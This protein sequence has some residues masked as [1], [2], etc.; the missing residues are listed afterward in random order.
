MKENRDT[1]QEKRSP[2]VSPP[3]DVPEYP[4]AKDTAC[5]RNLETLSVKNFR[6]L[7]QYDGTH[8]HGWQR[9]PNGLTIQESIENCLR[10]IT[11]ENTAISGAGRTDAG[12]HALGQTV[13]FS[14]KTRHTPEIFMRALN[15][16][17]PP[18]IRALSA[19]KAGDSFHARFS[20]KTKV[21]CYVIAN[22]SHVSPFCSRYAWHVPQ[23]L[24]PEPMR[25]SLGCLIG[26]NDFS[27]FR[28]SGCMSLSPVRTILGTD[29][30]VCERLPF[31]PFELGGP[32]FVIR[33]EADSFLR[34]MVR[35]IVGTVYEIGSGRRPH[36]DMEAVLVAR[37]RMRA[38]MTAPPVGLFLE[39]VTY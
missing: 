37:K 28:A 13:S 1:V 14:A 20:A 33:I 11:G 26:E 31:L 9:Q 21:Y 23:P 12:V 7:F 3:H 16:M 29:L 8:Y 6:L 36:D 39:K 30:I 38:G 5:S 19:E 24:D 25:E 18:D 32:F 35:N 22:A 2:F 17:L 27:S 10:R 34:R 15:A 4:P